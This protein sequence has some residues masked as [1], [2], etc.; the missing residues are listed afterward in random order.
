MTIGDQDLKGLPG[1]VSALAD[2]HDLPAYSGKLSFMNGGYQLGIG[3]VLIGPGKQE[4]QIQ[5]FLYSEVLQSGSGPVSNARQFCQLH[6][7]SVASFHL[8]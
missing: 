8:W 5:G 1:P 2:G 4:Y 7:L 3:A 6:P